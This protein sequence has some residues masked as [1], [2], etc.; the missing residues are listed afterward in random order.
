MGRPESCFDAEPPGFHGEKIACERGDG[1]TGLPR[2]I[3]I[4][5]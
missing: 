5:I 4:R 3:G 2:K 1:K